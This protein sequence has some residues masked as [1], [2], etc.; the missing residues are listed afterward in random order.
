MKRTGLLFAFAALMAVAGC[1]GGV[2]G[3]GGPKSPDISGK[4]KGEI[5]MNASSKDDPMAK[6]GEA[7]AQMMLGNLTLEFLPGDKFKLSMMGMPIEGSYQRSGNELTL[8][9]EQAMGMSAE[10]MKES[11]PK[12]STDTLKATVSEDGTQITVRNDK[13]KTEEGEMVFKRYTEDAK[14]DVASTVSGA[15]KPLVGSYKCEFEG[16]KPA[17]M[18]AQEES[19]WKMGEAMM[20]AAT[21]D[22]YADNT[23]KINLMLEMTGK[24]KVE[25]GEAKLHMTGMAGMPEDGK[26]SGKNDMNLRI[27]PGGRLVL[28]GKGPANMKM[29][30]VKN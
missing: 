28:D 30:F 23:F 10:E 4:W 24:W 25:G 20:S 29:A 22:L 6:F 18:T 11:D 7:M 8:K 5:K 27:E 21:L 19:E 26:S 9:P 1:K 14:K 16:E 3:I 12:F 2:M 13:G 17:K 15:E